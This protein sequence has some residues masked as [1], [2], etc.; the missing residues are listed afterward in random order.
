MLTEKTKFNIILIVGIVI[1][2]NVFYSSWTADDFLVELDRFNPETPYKLSTSEQWSGELE[3][4]QLGDFY[5]CIL[6]Y[7][8]IA[9]VKRKPGDSKTVYVSLPSGFRLTL[10]TSG[11]EVNQLFLFKFNSDGSKAEQSGGVAVNCPLSLLN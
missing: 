11:G 2:A 8:D 10:H 9:W 5:T 4:G 3:D 1:F 7:R 6:N